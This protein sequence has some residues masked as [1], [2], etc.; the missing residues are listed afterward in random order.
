[1]EADRT[2]SPAQRAGLEL[3]VVSRREE[4]LR[5]YGQGSLALAE[6]Q[7]LEQTGKTL[8]E[9]IRDIRTQ[10]VISTYLERNL[11][12]LINVTRRDIERFYRDNYETFNPAPKRE[13]NLIYSASPPDTEWFTS[14]LEAGVPFNE[15]ALDDRNA[16]RGADMKLALEGD[17]MFEAEINEAIKPLEAGQWVG[18]LPNRGQ[19]WFV[20]IAS[21]DRPETRTLFEA[22]VDIERALRTQQERQ[23]QLELGEKLRRGASFTDEQ[24]MTEAVLDIAVARYASQ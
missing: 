8:Q 9:N 1:D 6:R 23:L 18:P 19:D 2:L 21:L 5:R 15:L 16:F 14:Q 24:R 11:R 10:I 20:Y 13:V 12:P 22:Q 4:L 3:F 17:D 7:I